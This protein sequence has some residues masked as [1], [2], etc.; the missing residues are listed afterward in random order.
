MLTSNN[1]YFA[2]VASVNDLASEIEHMKSVA[3]LYTVSH[4]DATN[5]LVP[6]KMLLQRHFHSQTPS[7]QVCIYKKLASS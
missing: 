7:M 2:F 5:A 4:Q 1:K 6:P 3:S